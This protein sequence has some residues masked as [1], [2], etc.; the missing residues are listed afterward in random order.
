MKTIDLEAELK[1]IEQELRRPDPLK[2][3]EPQDNLFYTL[4]T[5]FHA[6]MRS[7]GC[8]MEQALSELRKMYG[9]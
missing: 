3:R 9:L 4:E 7:R 1:A 6:I 5:S 8:S 2:L